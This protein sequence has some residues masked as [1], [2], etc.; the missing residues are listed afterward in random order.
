MTGHRVSGIVLAAGTSSRL[1]GEVPKQLLEI[2]GRTLLEG[3]AS[4]ALG[5]RLAEVVVVLGHAAERVAAAAGGLEVKI[6]V[7]PD[8]SRGQST[9]VRAGLGQIDAGAHGALF[10]PADQP[11]LSS[12][13]IDRLIDAHETELRRENPKACLRRDR[14]PIVVPTYRGRRGAPVLFD[15][16]YFAELSGL[17]GDVG[18]RALFE[19]Y[20]SHIVEVTVDDPSE[21]ADVDTEADLHRLERLLANHLSAL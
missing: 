11:L 4:A 18:G 10:M 3:V 19:R 15:R 5:S 13:L 20:G 7:N 8:F 14:G 17:E 12:R 9:S 1:A 2:G 21:L 6:V 16:A